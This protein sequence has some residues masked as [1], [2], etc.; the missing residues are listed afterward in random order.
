VGLSLFRI[1]K[2]KIR[3]ID[4]YIPDTVAISLTENPKSINNPNK[5]VPK[6]VAKTIKAVVKALMDPRYFTP[7]N[8]AQVEEPKTLANPLEIP[9]KPKNTK[10]VTGTS[11]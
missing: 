1:K 8:S 9:T 2:S 5:A 4:I 11:K 7:Y 6:A 10:A 3:D